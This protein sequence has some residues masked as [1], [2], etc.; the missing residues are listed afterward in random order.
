[1]YDE[2]YKISRK[3][4]GIFA[5]FNVFTTPKIIIGLFII[6]PL[7]VGLVSGSAGIVRGILSNEFI[8]F[9]YELMIRDTFIFYVII[10]C[11]VIACLIFHK[12]P[13][14]PIL[15]FK[16][17]M[18]INIYGAAF[19]ALSYFFG[20]GLKFLLDITAFV[21]MFFI[22][23]ALLSYITI[24]TILFS[25]TTVETPL[26]I[27]LALIEP[28]VGILLFSI[29][30][31]DESTILFFLIRAAIFFCSGALIFAIP[32]SANMLS[33]SKIY[34]SKTGIGGYNF[35]RAFVTC[36]LLDNQ[37]D[38]IERYFDEIGVESSLN[39]QYIGIKSLEKKEIK[40]LFVI[41]DVHFGPFKT[42]GS[43]A[44]PEAIYNRF[45]NIPGLS[46]F[47]TTTT[48][49]DNFTNHRFNDSVI[50]VMEENIDKFDFK[51]LKATEFKRFISGKAKILG[52]SIN[53]EN[54]FMIITRHPF[55]Q[56]DMEP[57]IGKEISNISKNIGFMKQ[58]YII[59]AHNAI[60]GDE[61]LVKAD[62]EEGKEIIDVSKTCLEQLKDLGKNEQ[63]D[64]EYGVAH[65]SMSEF[66]VEHG[67]GNGGITVHIFKINNQLTALIHFDGNNAILDVRSRIINLGENKGIDRIEITTSDSH[68]TARV[69]SAQGYYPIGKKIPIHVIL[70]KL[71]ILIDTAMNN[72]EKVEIATMQTKTP[73]FR[74]WGDLSYFEVVLATI[75]KCMHTSMNLLTISVLIPM[76]FSILIATLYYN[77]PLIP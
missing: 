24:F 26:N 4:P 60:I 44:L 53:N 17:S 7:L 5:L 68:T 72:I 54:P 43:A 76:L 49:A 30:T 71:N 38:L 32:Y 74:K 75:E 65:D 1:M 37:D 70:N 31:Q 25:F 42:A 20:R 57:E 28:I 22:L 13:K 27:F 40:G 14:V 66:P 18:L 15:N 35:V 46:V 56:D 48:H 3:S 67:I 51:R 2:T 23:G 63:Y 19:F 36:L 69:L 62:R 45:S 21:E 6:S 50:Q 52:L 8:G 33:V 77:I 29:F 12:V 10:G 59:D 64:I 47:H 41:P 58:P 73:G 34:R 11:G 39:M 61:F 55:P 16:I 9:N